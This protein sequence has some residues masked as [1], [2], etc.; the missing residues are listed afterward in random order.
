[1]DSPDSVDVQKSF[2]RGMECLRESVFNLAREEFERVL[3]KDPEFAPGWFWLGSIDAIQGTRDR[4]IERW[5]RCVEIAPGFGEAHYA[6]SWAYYD[7]GDHEKGYEH[8]NRGLD[9]GVSHGSV[10]G[11]IENFLR[12]GEPKAFERQV[13]LSDFGQGGRQ[14]KIKDVGPKK[15]MSSE[16]LYQR[17]IV[18]LRER[19]LDNAVDFLE[20]AV[21]LDPS[22][23]EAHFALGGAYSRKDQLINAA[24]E[25]RITLELDPDNKIA[26]YALMLALQQIELRERVIDAGDIQGVPELE[27]SIIK[28]QKDVD[29]RGDTRKPPD[30]ILRKYF[31]AYKHH[32]LNVAIVFSY[33]LFLGLILYA[34]IPWTYTQAGADTLKHLYKTKFIID[35]WPN[36]QWN[37]QW[38][39]GMP[40]LVTYPPFMYFL[41][42]SIVIITNI[43]IELS[44]CIILAFSACI[45]GLGMYGIILE[46][47]EEKEVALFSALLISS[48]PI[49]WRHIVVFGM[50]MDYSGIAFSA[51]SIWIII[52]YIKKCNEDR[53]FINSYLYLGI[54]S[55][56]LAISFHSLIGTVNCA[57]CCI[58]SLIGIKYFNHK[59]YSFFT[60]STFSFLTSSYYFFRLLSQRQV[61]GSW[62]SFERGIPTQTSEP[63]DRI[64][65][66]IELPN[67]LI[68]G[69]TPLIS[70]LLLISLTTIFLFTWK[71]ANVKKM[72]FE[73][74]KIYLLIF[75]LITTIIVVSY[76][77]RIFQYVYILVLFPLYVTCLIGIL[78]SYAFRTAS[79][80][81]DRSFSR[82]PLLLSVI[83]IVSTLIGSGVD[84]PNRILNISSLE[85]M[86]ESDIRI[87]DGDEYRVGISERDGT[88]AL[89]F[90]YRFDTP[91]T[92]HYGRND[93]PYPKWEYLA[94]NYIWDPE[95]S[96]E[97]TDFLL[98]WWGVRWIIARPLFGLQK[99][100]NKTDS[101]HL[102]Q[103]SG[104]YRVFE[105]ENSS[106]IVS[107]TDS[108]TMLVIG[109]ESQYYLVFRSL[110]FSNTNTQQIIPI[111]GGKDVATFSPD[112]LLMFDVIM[113]YGQDFK[114]HDE[115][116]RLLADYVEKGGGLIIETADVQE[117][118]AF[119]L[120]API[121]QVYGKSIEDSWQL[122]K[123][124]SDETRGISL[125]LFSPPTWKSYPWKCSTTT[126]SS[127][128]Q[129]AE[130]L[131]WQGDDP[132]MV[133][134]SYGSGSVIWSG[135]NLPFHIRE[136]K[137]YIE[138]VLF[139]NIIK[140]VQA[141]DFEDRNDFEYAIERDNP[142]KLIVTINSS[143][144]IGILFKEFYV[145]NWKCEIK[146]TGRPLKIFS[147]GPDFM[148]VSLS[149]ETSI[150]STIIFS[151]SSNNLEK[152]GLGITVFLLLL[153]LYLTI[154]GSKFFLYLLSRIPSSSA[155]KEQSH[156]L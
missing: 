126:N 133:K 23:S 87:P 91:Q 4:A 95:S 52:K 108:P 128:R 80:R 145:S 146:N 47:T 8:L 29:G 82:I 65:P 67:N 79:N 134:W 142:Q 32:L 125:D 121:D 152:I 46:I 1:M 78:L 154:R 114:D 93:R 149:N 53:K 43:S 139:S 90:N 18:A 86:A 19:R 33:A 103:E 112:E 115:S 59:I 45:L 76:I 85:P 26:Q 64:K 129:G 25:W 13:D 141:K 89:W 21:S 5:K 109:D 15:E 69:N 137:N 28:R 38:A 113:L 120:P 27:Q 101:Y 39:A 73:I 51:L 84:V 127:L 17:G 16:L 55:S 124:N 14:E 102:L 148:Y 136:N 97:E 41:M 31:H 119:P 110:S 135:L 63:L 56:T 156:I 88:I 94:S 6:L 130:T 131:L 40:F 54:F 116:W 57:L 10:K 58:I 77:L 105:Y 20:Q 11:L 143:D 100:V 74:H 24:E 140:S 96:Y 132:I 155:Q 151:Y 92:R 34:W 44:Y 2:E 36:W 22:N 99:F 70:W 49:Y 66:I 118:E 111:R 144:D 68:T 104:D 7:A 12:K 153:Y 50:G 122:S 106:K 81:F 48:T 150:K 9:S 71:K 62:L 61:L 123:R 3:S 30:D 60:I 147:A 42:A 83:L 138:S 37:D 107:V 98:D 75:G 35:N 72:E 117:R